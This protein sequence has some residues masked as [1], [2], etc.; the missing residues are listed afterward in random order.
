MTSVNIKNTIQSRIDALAGA[1]AH[2]RPFL[3]A[4]EGK[5][6]SG[7][8]TLAAELK[9][10]Y[11]CNLFTTDD[12]FLQ[13]RQQTPDRLAEIGGNIDYERFKE[14][15]IEPLK[16]GRAFTYRRYDCQTQSLSDEIRVTP[17][18]LNII[19]GVYSMHPYFGDIYGFTIFLSI[20]EQEQTRRLM[21]R[22]PKLYEKFVNGW[23][24]ME[25]KYFETF[26][27]AER[28]GLVVN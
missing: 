13:P 4:I 19:E 5:S 28:C 17:K 11:D 25:N 15:I 7:K 8:T 2:N 14:E 9:S 6:T 12:F 1:A 18:P 24:P 16:Q 23:I 10:T 27:I 21:I 22:N 26:K 20:S 3:I